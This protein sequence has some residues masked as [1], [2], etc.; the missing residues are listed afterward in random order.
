MTPAQKQWLTDNPKYEPV[1]PPRV[2]VYFPTWGTLYADGHFEGS[3]SGMD[4]IRL[5]PGCVGVGIKEGTT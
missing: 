4:A 5:E 3:P 1:G 2:G